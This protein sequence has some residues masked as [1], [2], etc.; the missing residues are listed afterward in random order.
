M[1]FTLNTLCNKML[2]DSFRRLIVAGGIFMFILFCPT[3]NSFAQNKQVQ[4]GKSDNI[5][6]APDEWKEIFKLRSA[7]NKNQYGS[8]YVMGLF[9][10]HF[11]GPNDEDNY[12]IRTY[13]TSWDYLIFGNSLLE[14]MVNLGITADN[15]NFMSS[16]DLENHHPYN[17]GCI[18]HYSISQE[19]SWV[20]S[21][22]NK[23]IGK[24]VP[25]DKP[26]KSSIPK[27]GIDSGLVKADVAGFYSKTKAG[28]KQVY[29]TIVLP[30]IEGT[31]SWKD[32][33]NFDMVYE[34]LETFFLQYCDSI[35][36]TKRQFSKKTPS[37][38]RQCILQRFN[39]K[40][41]LEENNLTE[42]DI[43][44]KM[45]DLYKNDIFDF[46]H[47][48]NEKVIRMGNYEFFRYFN[49]IYWRDINETV[50]MIGRGKDAAGEL[51][52][53]AYVWKPGERKNP[54]WHCAF[55][56]DK[57]REINPRSGLINYLMIPYGTKGRSMPTVVPNDL[58]P[59]SQF[60]GVVIWSEGC[61]K[62]GYSNKDDIWLNTLN[63]RMINRSFFCY[64]YE[65]GI[66]PLND[67]GTVDGIYKIYVWKDDKP[68]WAYIFCGKH[69]AVRGGKPGKSFVDQVDN[70]RRNYDFSDYW[71]FYKQVD[72]TK[73][74]VKNMPVFISKLESLERKETGIGGKTMPRI[75]I[76]IF[77]PN[78]K[79]PK[80]PK[81]DNYYILLNGD[82]TGVVYPDKINVVW[83]IDEYDDF[84]NNMLVKKKSVIINIAGQNII[85]DGFDTFLKNNQFSGSQIRKANEQFVVYQQSIKKKPADINL[86]ETYNNRIFNLANSDETSKLIDLIKED[87][88]AVRYELPKAEH[89]L[90]DWQDHNQDHMDAL[91]NKLKELEQNKK[92]KTDLYLTTKEEYDKLKLSLD[93]KVFNH[94]KLVS[95]E[96][97]LNEL[98]L[99]CNERL[100][101][102]LD[103]D[104][105]AI[106]SKITFLEGERKKYEV[107]LEQMKAEGK[108]NNDGYE[109]VKSSIANKKQELNEAESKRDTIKRLIENQKRLQSNE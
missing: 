59:F 53:Y 31:G 9:D 18:W 91:K 23:T 52:K 95:R 41:Y 55:Q 54:V 109:Q 3:I 87:L 26:F 84:N 49:D 94:E 4:Y 79:N 28:K 6:K 13:T 21:A 44:Y 38:V 101:I 77:T 104:L 61:E 107:Q 108:T 56:Y 19:K 96:D 32:P 62:Q 12:G 92:T 42:A 48:P 46:L 85:L 40:K 69:A 10:G 86:N 76:P 83:K 36:I 89:T 34:W 74:V 78:D 97:M 102:N 71:Y 65:V 93:K 105:S 30:Q 39:T 24:N 5:K 82:N 103:N 106:E 80:K 16:K 47:E 11:I 35:D 27:L 81:I 20:D 72:F 43:S 2:N 68:Y 14:M 66:L 1:T 37:D 67:D 63:G 50:V 51:T 7:F 73:D 100:N 15:I 25:V 70:F 60:E 64:T 17:L 8:R 98:L 22:Y 88:S 58:P 57:D 33:N 45:T 90:E 99:K 29:D 75:H